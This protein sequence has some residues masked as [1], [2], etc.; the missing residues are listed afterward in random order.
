MKRTSVVKVRFYPDEFDRI[1]IAAAPIKPAVWLR[2]VASAAADSQRENRLARR[3]EL[4]LAVVY[5]GNEIRHLSD[6]LVE[7]RMWSEESRAQL[8]AVHELLKAALRKT[9]SSS[10]GGIHAK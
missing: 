5:A 6:Q 2:D 4:A 1:R 10:R 9:K 8:A 3:Y 7:N